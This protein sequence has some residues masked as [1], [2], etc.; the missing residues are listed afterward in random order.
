ME[1]FGKLVL[2]R[3]QPPG[4]VE[5]EGF[6]EGSPSLFISCTVGQ[7]VGLYRVS[8]FVGLPALPRI[9]AIRSAELSL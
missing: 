3:S 9:L 5:R 8:A 6:P 2:G 7:C 1:S 4:T